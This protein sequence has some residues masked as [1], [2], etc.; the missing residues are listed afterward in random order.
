[1]DST[2]LQGTGSNT[3]RGLDRRQFLQSGVAM[4]AVGAAGLGLLARAAAAEADDSIKAFKVAVPASEIADLRRRLSMVRWSTAEIVP[5]ASQGVPLARMKALV[6]YWQQGYDWRRFE[7]QINRLPQFRTTID[8]LGIHFIHVPS[9][10]A[11]ATPLLLTH[12][13]PGSVVEFLKVVEPLANPTAHGGRAED[14][15]HLVI[16]SLPGFGFSDQPTAPGWNMARIANAWSVLMQRLGYTRWV[17]QGGDWGAAVATWMGKLQVPGLAAIHLNLPILFPPPIEGKPTDEEKKALAQLQ[18]YRDDLGAYAKLMGTR[19]QT[20][21][22]ALNDSPVGQAAWIY[23][24]FVEWTDT[25]G[26]PESVLSR[27]VM[28]DN[29]SLYWFTRTGASSARLYH[30]SFGKDFSTQKVDV[31]VAVSLFPGEFFHP[32]RVWGERVYSRLAYWNEAPRGGH[33]A[34]LEQPDLFVSELRKAFSAAR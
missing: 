22:Y 16:P 21:G 1:M 17:A 7:A 3:V 11:D 8:G 20:I 33:F 5:D 18:R 10:H 23:E 4:A 6:D 28:L 2:S 29:I 19:P 30:E 13:W 9:P 14:A 12:G 26:N 32:P 34:A 27:D 15:F 25:N 31:P 24:K